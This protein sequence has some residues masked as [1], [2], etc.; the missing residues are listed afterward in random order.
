MALELNSSPQASRGLAMARAAEAML[1]VLGGGEVRLLLPAI[2]VVDPTAR[3]LGVDAPDFEEVAVSPVVVRS[4]AAG[5]E[6]LFPAAAISAQVEERQAGS[7]EALFNSAAGAVY[8][9]RTWRVVGCAAEHF[10]GTPYLY[11]VRVQ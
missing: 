2:A 7:A 5:V 8:D 10:A 1:R 6:L 4:A 11:R 3:Q 9:G